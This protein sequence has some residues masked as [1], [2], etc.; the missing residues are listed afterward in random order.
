MY[1]DP[2]S[3]VAVNPSEKCVPGDDSPIYD[4]K[5]PNATVGLFQE[6]CLFLDIYV[7]L[8]VLQS[9]TTKAS[10]AVWFF[11]GAFL[12]GS[13]HEFDITQLPLY[14]GTGVLSV[15]S[16][17]LI[18]VAGNYRLG[19]FGWLA[20]SYME[21]AGAPNAG[22]L[23]QRMIL[24]FVQQHIG[25]VNGDSSSVSAWGESA[26]AGSILHH[27]VAKNGQQDPLFSRAILQSP[28]YQ[29]QWNRTG[30]L[31]D[32]YSQFATFAK[33]FTGDMSCLQSADESTLREANQ[34]LF[35]SKSACQGIFPVG[36]SLDN[37]LVL[38]LPA[39]ALQ[40]GQYIPF[41]F[42]FFFFWHY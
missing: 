25:K 16:E 2:V 32:T 29:W 33:C 18:F 5:C 39:V 24:S 3:C 27:L 31:N 7:P 21:T 1:T 17:P 12:F 42:V 8:S 30:T 15:A 13:K 36:P 4:P 41:V 14:S 10:V 40:N 11:G 23:D 26:G 35:R 38:T 28:A 37:S 22:L 19:A 9:T 20:G 34:E 6:D